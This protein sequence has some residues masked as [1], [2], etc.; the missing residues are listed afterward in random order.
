MECGGV[1]CLLF[2]CLLVLARPIADDGRSRSRKKDRAQAAVE[3][4]LF[5]ASYK[6]QPLL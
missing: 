6:L 4:L 2:Q 5:D 3:D 1:C